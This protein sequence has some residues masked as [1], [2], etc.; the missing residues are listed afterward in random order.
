M[1][2]STIVIILVFLGLLGGVYLAKQQPAEKG[3]TRISLASVD[4]DK[5]D[6]VE[7]HQKKDETIELKKKD[8][9]WTVG[10]EHAAAKNAMDG[11][12]S[13]IE[14]VESSDLVTSDPEHYGRFGV[15]DDEGIHVVAKSQGK[16]KANFI[17]GKVATGGSY[18]RVGKDVFLVKGVY[19]Y[20]FERKKG[21]WYRL[22][23]FDA[24]I[25]D[26]KGATLGPKDAPYRLEKQDDGTWAL[27]KDIEV[28][29]GFRFDPSVA[30]SRVSTLVNLRA[31]ELVTDAVDDA[32]TGL[33]DPV[34]VSFSTGDTEHVLEIGKAKE[35]DEQ[36]IYGR[37]SGESAVY[38]LYKHNVEQ[39]T[40]PMAK[41]RALTLMDFDPEKARRLT[42]VDGKKRLVLEKQGAEW[43]IARSSEPIPDDFV[44]DQ[45]R[46]RQR[47]TAIKN[48]RALGIF[49]KGTLASLGLKAPAVTITVE[50]EEG[51]PAV[52]RIG[53]KEK[54]EKAEW[55]AATG[56]IDSAIYGLSSWVKN[57]LTGG[58]DTFKKTKPTAAN[59]DPSQLQ[60]LPPDVREALEKKMKE[61]QALQALAAKAAAAQK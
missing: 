49:E 1:S 35:G 13:A 33:G 40:A 38:L 10:G 36:S 26:V 34:R 28:P 58:I 30:G 37:V 25:A 39:L 21:L 53:K 61:K 6:E 50:L 31:K 54:V 2:K 46:V 14:Q 47:L 15:K 52:L 5:L 27:A 43:K 29:A 57:N 12:L 55:F 22:K 3:I 17:V 41:L 48:A 11:L 16:E 45:A 42:I 51:S 23:L 32:K 18:V 44:L 60:G 7:I 24:K 59:L 56:N 19:R 4:T 20:T 9:T 8:G